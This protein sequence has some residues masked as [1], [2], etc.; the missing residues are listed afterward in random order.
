MLFKLIL[1][2][3]VAVIVVG[4]AGPHWGTI[5]GN[6]API[7]GPLVDN[8]ALLLKDMHEATSF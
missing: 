5:S 3:L 8:L 2:V 6:L 4:V 1:F 7:V